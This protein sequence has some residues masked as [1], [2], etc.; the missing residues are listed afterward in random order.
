VVA[1]QRADGGDVRIAVVGRVARLRADDPNAIARRPARL[2]RLMPRI[3][4]IH[5]EV[6]SE[7]PTPAVNGQ[8]LSVRLSHASRS[9]SSFAPAATRVGTIGLIATAGEEKLVRWREFLGC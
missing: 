5:G 7:T 2:R 4:T 3:A 9:I 6:D 1:R 8:V